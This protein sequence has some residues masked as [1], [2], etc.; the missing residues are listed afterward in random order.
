MKVGTL[1]Q[2]GA[3]DAKAVM[4]QGCQKFFFFWLCFVVLQV[5]VF[6][7]ILQWSV[8]GELVSVME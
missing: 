4:L 1:S 2:M 8:F 6:N 3:H 5:I 7:V